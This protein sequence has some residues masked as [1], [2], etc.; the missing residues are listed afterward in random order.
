[1]NKV[2]SKGLVFI[3]LVVISISIKRDSAQTWDDASITLA[4]GGHPCQCQFLTIKWHTAQVEQR[5]EATRDSLFNN[6]Q[7]HSLTG[8]LPST[9]SVTLH[10]FSPRRHQLG[11]SQS[12]CCVAG[13]FN[14]LQVQRPSSATAPTQ[15]EWARR[16]CAPSWAPRA[17]ANG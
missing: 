13:S 8:Q 9:S 16:A 7:M 14:P 3:P 11:V 6:P 15:S 4:V 1:M 12:W 17:T 2:E 10:S 5:E